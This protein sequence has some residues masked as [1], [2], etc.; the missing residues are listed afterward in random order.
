MSEC[1]IHRLLVTNKRRMPLSGS[2]HC[3][4]QLATPGSLTVF[5]RVRL[6]GCE[7]RKVGVEGDLILLICSK[8]I[9]GQMRT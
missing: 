9:S 8:T 2:N 4:G 5:G 6:A 1:G 7:R 3:Q